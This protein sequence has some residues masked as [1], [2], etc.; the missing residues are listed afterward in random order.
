MNFNAIT[1]SSRRS[2]LFGSAATVGAILT[3]RSVATLPA[4]HVADLVPN[5]LS[6]YAVN[7]FEMGLG[8][9]YLSTL[10]KH[11]KVHLK[12]QLAKLDSIAEQIQLDIHRHNVVSLDGWLIPVTEARL[13]ACRVM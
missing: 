4:S 1:N 2:F 9:L 3:Q 6:G 11:E 10:D 13:W 12:A 8:Q 5:S 7:D